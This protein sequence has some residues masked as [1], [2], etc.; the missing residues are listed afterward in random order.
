MKT[1][2]HVRVELRFMARSVL[3]Q[4]SAVASGPTVLCQPIWRHRAKR[5]IYPTPT[6]EADRTWAEQTP[7]D[8][9]LAAAQQKVGPVLFKLPPR[10]QKD[11]SRIEGFRK[12]LPSAGATPSNFAIPVGT[13]RT[14]LTSC[15]TTTLHSVFQIITML[16]RRGL[17]RLVSF[18]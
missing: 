1:R 6:E 3:S 16:H 12:L 5:G 15:E 18:M 7:E 17:P 2:Q 10:F 13:K 8:L 14:F 4:S 9:V 11:S